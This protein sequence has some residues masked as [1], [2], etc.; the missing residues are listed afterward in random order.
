M[1]RRSTWIALGIF[2][3]FVIVAVLFDRSR[4][5]DPVATATPPSE[6]IWSVPSDQ[7]I[8]LIVEDL[9]AGQMV[10]LARDSVE[11]WI[12]VRPEE[13]PADAARV[14][15]AVSWLSSLR[16]RAHLPEVEDLSD[17]ALDDPLYRVELVLANGEHLLFTVGR[18]T[19]I[20]GSRYAAS[21]GIAGVVTLRTLELDNVLEL[22]G[23][24][25]LVG[26]E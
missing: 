2:V 10:E 7:V 5:N 8:G 12:I 14:E 1:I 18:E 3:A 6:P 13:L 25:P 22:A 23:D 21:P 20:G 19:P 4:G 11:L 9:A 24:L 16:P 15:R 17:F 26:E